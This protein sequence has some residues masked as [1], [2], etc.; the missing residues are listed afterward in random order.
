MIILGPVLALAALVKLL[1]SRAWVPLPFLV[2]TALYVALRR[3]RLEGGIG[4]GVVG[5]YAAAI[6]GVYLGTTLELKWLLQTTLDRMIGDLVPALVVLSL[7]EIWPAAGAKI[8]LP[9]TESLA[10][11]ITPA[12]SP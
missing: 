10:D 3:R 7:W 8:E 6:G 5:A 12:G 2:L 1:L 4:W 9:A 11:D